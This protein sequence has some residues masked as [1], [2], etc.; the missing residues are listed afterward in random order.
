[1]NL[2][3][4]LQNYYKGQ[5]MQHQDCFIT[6]KQLAAMAGMSTKTIRRWIKQGKVPAFQPGGKGC[7]I[8]IPKDRLRLD[9][10]PTDFLS[11]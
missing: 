9:M 7:D 1:M 11:K 6:P 5:P 4:L 3:F 10:L 2:L 8:L